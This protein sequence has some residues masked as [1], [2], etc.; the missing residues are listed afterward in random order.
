MLSGVTFAASIDDDALLLI[1][2]HLRIAD[3]LEFAAASAATSAALCPYCSHLGVAQRLAALSFG[4]MTAAS[5]TGGPVAALRALASPT[6]E[7]EGLRSAL[8]LFS[9]LGGPSA[10]GTPVRLLLD[11]LF[12]ADTNKSSLRSAAAA[13]ATLNA[14]MASCER[15]SAMY[16]AVT[17]TIRMVEH[18]FDAVFGEFDSALSIQIAYT[19][20]ARTRSGVEFLR[21]RL[22]QCASS[23][24]VEDS[25]SADERQLEAAI[26]SLDSTIMGYVEEGF[27]LGCPQFA[28]A[29]GR[30]CEVPYS[31]WWVYSV[32]RWSCLGRPSSNWPPARSCA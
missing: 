20:V 8:A 6:P 15:K 24:T 2:S 4:H 25:F 13:R 30:R 12:Q 23:D 16:L 1:F 27:D 18:K 5:S 32:G 19:E 17:E 28:S 3:F 7:G 26:E 22:A 10:A 31:H 14:M 9:Q 21:S 29:K 11:A